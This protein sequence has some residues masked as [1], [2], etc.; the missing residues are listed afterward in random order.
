MHVPR[1]FMHDVLCF[2]IGAHKWVINHFANLAKFGKGVL[3]VYYLYRRSER[4]VT[5]YAHP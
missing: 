2:A 1:T 5:I 3:L 4:Q